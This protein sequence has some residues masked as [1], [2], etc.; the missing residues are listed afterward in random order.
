VLLS[1][2]RC[3]TLTLSPCLLAYSAKPLAVVKIWSRSLKEPDLTDIGMA[4]PYLRHKDAFPSSFTSAVIVK[5]IKAETLG[6]SQSNKGF[7][8][9]YTALLHHKRCDVRP[10]SQHWWGPWLYYWLCYPALSNRLQPLF[11]CFAHSDADCVFAVACHCV[12]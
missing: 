11:W 2:V 7:H 9:S 1:L 6:L 4:P 5:P 3:S 12:R 8:R 10:L